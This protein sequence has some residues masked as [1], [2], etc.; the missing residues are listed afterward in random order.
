[1]VS[2][3]PAA[4]PLHIL[5][6]ALALVGLAVWA[7]WRPLRERPA[8]GAMLLVWRL[9]VVAALAMI[10]MG[11]S[12]E[13]AT[14]QTSRRPRV[15]ILLDTSASMLTADV[16]AQARVEFARTQWLTQER[17]RRL[18]DQFEVDLQR[19][20]ILT[21]PL[22]TS[23]LANDLRPISTGR[24]TRLAEAVLWTASRMPTSADPGSMLVLSDGHDTDQA[25]I[26]PAAALAR[27]KQIAISTVT[28]GGSRSE[29]DVALLAVPMQEYLLPNEPGSILVKVYQ[30][31]YE[32]EK[33]TL[34]WRQGETVKSMPIDFQQRR[35]VEVQVP[36]Q[37]AEPGE[38]EYTLEIDALPGEAESANNRQR[39]F[40]DVQRRRMRV[41]LLEGQPFWDT[42]F[43]AQALRKD[44]R[45]DLTQLTQV[46]GEKR[47]TLVTRTESQAPTVPATS[48]DW[49]Q[50][51]V[52]ILG[53]QVDRLLPDDGGKQLAKFVSDQGGT[54]FSPADRPP[55]SRHRKAGRSPP[56]WRSSSPCSGASGLVSSWACRSLP[57]AGQASGSPPPRWAST[58]RKPS[59]GFRALPSRPWSTVRSPPRWCSCGPRPT[60]ATPASPRYAQ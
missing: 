28:L 34:R 31:G 7:Y 21:Q 53:R 54:S 44:E 56:T 50:Y 15:S 41:L 5:A 45:I 20:D 46:T 51:D 27:T 25:S 17:L 23:Q 33:A 29:R 37:Q 3:Q 55:T 38:Y 49:A 59:H 6:G 10:L 12:R 8:A 48:E 57:P 19:F 40:A 13:V 18:S 9:L 2:W 24:G 43:L 52:V 11:P 60:P 32:N 36:I 47:E 26:Q 39:V 14:A 16:N 42:K 22:A 4:P 58:S 35:I 1:M 30:S